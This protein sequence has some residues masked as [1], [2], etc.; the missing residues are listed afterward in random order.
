MVL[1]RE[2]YC[3]HKNLF[4]CWRLHSVDFEVIVF[5][6]GFS[7]SQQSWFADG[8]PFRPRDVLL[9]HVLYE[10]PWLA[11]KWDSVV[12]VVRHKY[13]VMVIHIDAKWEFELARAVALVTKLEEPLSLHAVDFDAVVGVVGQDNAAMLIHSDVAGVLNVSVALSTRPELP[14]NTS[15]KVMDA[16]LG[17]RRVK[18]SDNKFVWRCH[19]N[20][21][22]LTECVFTPWV[23]EC[24]LYRVDLDGFIFTARGYNRVLHLIYCQTWK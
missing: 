2:F 1:K 16:D 9:Y 22:G 5:Y 17:F 23:D 15:V 13:V 14:Y 4:R 6:A 11:E 12:T 24:A 18:V 20:S 19:G 21:M 7:Q 10:L 3:I 8:K